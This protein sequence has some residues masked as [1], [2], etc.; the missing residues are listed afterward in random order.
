MSLAQRSYVKDHFVPLDFNVFLV[1]T[2]LFLGFLLFGC[3]MYVRLL[4]M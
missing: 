2:E 3:R 4:L 1:V